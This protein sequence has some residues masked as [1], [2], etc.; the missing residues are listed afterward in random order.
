MTSKVLLVPYLPYKL[1][2]EVEIGYEH[3]VDA[4]VV[5]FGDPQLLSQISLPHSPNEVV[6]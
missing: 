3:S 6:F 1:G 5:S 2:W 4:V